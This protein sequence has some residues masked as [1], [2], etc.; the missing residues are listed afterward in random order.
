MWG[1]LLFGLSAVLIIVFVAAAEPPAKG[2]VVGR[3]AKVTGKVTVERDGQ[4]LPAGPG[5][6]VLGGDIVVTEAKSEAAIDLGDGRIITVKEKSHFGMDE[7]GPE[8]EESSSGMLYYGMVYVRK[9]SG[10]KVK[11]LQIQTPSAVAGVRG[12]N[13]GV[14][15]APDGSSRFGVEEGE[16]SIETDG[17]GKSTVGVMQEVT[18]ESDD[19]VKLVVQQYRPDQN[20][21][22]DWRRQ[23]LEQVLKNPAPVVRKLMIRITTL[24]SRGGSVLAH[25][26]YMIGETIKA[27]RKSQDFKRQGQGDLYNQ[28]RT[29]I[30]ALLQDLL[31]TLRRLVRIDNCIT[32][33]KRML[34]VILTEATA[35]GS[36]TPPRQAKLIKDNMQKIMAVEKE[37]QKLHQGR[38]HVMRV[39]VPELKEAIADLI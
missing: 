32:A 14:A 16:L 27:A 36:P 37:A 1:K 35:E 2:G 13:F 3:L 8:R 23:R 17:G 4:T 28:Q 20:S 10:G 12:T 9:P 7:G 6:E 11:Q 26:E 30:F 29:F 19:Q 39:K 5:M 22:E 18:V 31:P 25:A 21:L 34:N 15:V 33:R 38:L 24:I